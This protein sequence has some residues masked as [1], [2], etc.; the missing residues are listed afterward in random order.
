MAKQCFDGICFAKQAA[1]VNATVSDIYTSLEG[2]QA[3]RDFVPTKTK[4][5][6]K[7]FTKITANNSK[8]WE[9]MANNSK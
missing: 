8:Q 5:E 1:A 4:T 7:I 9:T 6:T 2:R 3:K